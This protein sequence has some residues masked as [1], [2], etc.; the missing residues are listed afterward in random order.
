MDLYSD[1]SVRLSTE[2]GLSLTSH[3]LVLTLAESCTGGLAS[4]AIT[5]IAGSSTWFDRGFI[6]YS[7]ASKET[8]LSVPTS[9]IKDYGAVSEQTAKAMVA[10]AL[11]HSHANIAASI[12]GIA[13]PTGGN[14]EKPVG[15]VCFAWQIKGDNA[16][17]TIECF[18]GN[19]QEVRHQAVIRTL[20]G[21]IDMLN[22]KPYG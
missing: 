5:E 2:L 21:L 20:Y 13:G 14:A 12:T 7:N 1:L 8:L 11:A 17:T 9:T 18:K 10:G 3:N 19:R 6:T 22:A 15:T 16:I 4:A